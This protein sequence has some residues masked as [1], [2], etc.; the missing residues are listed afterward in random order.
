MMFACAF[1]TNAV[2]SECRH[3]AFC[4]GLK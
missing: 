4:Q 1:L 3:W 2:V